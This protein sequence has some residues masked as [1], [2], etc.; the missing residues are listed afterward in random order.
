MLFEGVQD[1]QQRGDLDTSTIGHR[2]IVASSFTGGPR[3]MAQ[4]FQDAMA[5][6]RK[7][8]K[9]DY[10]VTFT[11]NP[12]WPEVKAELELGQSSSDRP[13][14]TARVFKMKLKALMHDLVQNHVLR[15]VIGHIHVVEFQKRGLPHAHILLILAGN[16][17]PLSPD[18]YDSVVCAE[19][20]N[21][22]THPQLYATVTSSMRHGPCGKSH[23]AAKSTQ[24]AISRYM[25]MEPS[26]RFVFCYCSHITCLF[27]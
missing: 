1:A 6:V 25:Q 23:F 4:L 13:D 15:K 24:P 12:N 22:D 19:I 14:L 18:D 2:I 26:Q 8:F 17:K 11:C 16:D 20:P 5:I 21:P 27:K 10:F 7:L 3:Y 9:P